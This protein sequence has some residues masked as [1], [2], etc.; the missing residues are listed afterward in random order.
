MS[1]TYPPRR[2]ARSIASVLAGIFARVILTLRTDFVP[3]RISVFP[4]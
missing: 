3:H 2:M 1:E 4:P